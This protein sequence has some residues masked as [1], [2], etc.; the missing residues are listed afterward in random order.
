MDRLNNWSRWYRMDGNLHVDDA[1]M[2]WLYNE[3][4]IYP[5]WYHIM[6]S[7]WTLVHSSNR[8]VSWG[9]S[10][11]RVGN[12]CPYSVTW[13]QFIWE[14]TFFSTAAAF[15]LYPVLFPPDHIIVPFLK[16]IGH[17]QGPGTT[18]FTRCSI[19]WQMYWTQY[20]FSFCFENVLSSSGILTWFTAATAAFQYVRQ[21]LPTI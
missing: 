2:D 11:C 10:Q 12:L 17:L 4:L 19:L 16:N 3:S 13:N 8:Q 14:I 1:Q 18:Y 20:A 15:L 9:S 6:W 21:A 7:P 5:E